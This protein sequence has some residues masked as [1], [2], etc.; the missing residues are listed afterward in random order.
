MVDLFHKKRGSPFLLVHLIDYTLSTQE[1]VEEIFPQ[2]GISA[3]AENIF[4]SKK[5]KRLRALVGLFFFINP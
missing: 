3:A 5:C 1:K 4:N 2:A